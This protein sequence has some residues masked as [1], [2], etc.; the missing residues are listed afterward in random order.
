MDIVCLCPLRAAS[1]VWQ[2][3]TGAYALTVIVKATFLLKPGQSV[4]APEQNPVN[5]TERYVADDSRRSLH[6]PSDRAPYKPR[7]DVVLVG[8]AYAPGRQLVRSLVARMGVG[9]IDKSIEVWCD[10]GVRLHDGQLLKGPRFAQAAIGWEKAA[11]GPGTNNPVGISFDGAPNTFGMV[12]IPNVQPFGTSV[13]QRSDRFA[14]AGFGPIGRRWPLR[15]QKLGRYAGS[16]QEP[17]WERSALPAD[18]DASYFQAAPPDQQVAEIRPDERIFLENLHSEHPRLMTALPGL[19]PRAIA[20]RATGEREEVK[21][22]ADTLWID[23]DRGLCCVVWRGRVGLRH[24]AE[25]GRIAVWVDGLPVVAPEDALVSPPIKEEEEDGLATMTTVGPMV[26]MAEPVLPFVAGASKLAPSNQQIAENSSRWAIP[27]G[28]SGDGSGTM[29]ASLSAPMKAPLPFG[30][31]RD[32]QENLAETI[33]PLSSVESGGTPFVPVVVPLL[34]PAH[35]EEVPVLGYLEPAREEARERE[36]S[37]V[38]VV[39]PPAMIGP[40]A[41]VTQDEPVETDAAPA[42]KAEDAAAA[43]VEEEVVELSIEETAA[44]AAEIAEDKEERRK[45]L[46]AHGL[47]DSAWRRNET[48][49]D[50]AMEEEQGRGRNALRKRYDAAYVK[51]VEGFRG[52]ITVEEYARIMVGMERGNVEA[53][54]DG[55]RVQKKAMMPVVRVWAGRMGADVRVGKAAA[56]ALQELRLS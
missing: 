30:A 35:F 48:R 16:F 47:S 9:S 23:T 42:A 27:I 28:A 21:L 39:A 36:A 45:V 18:F 4:L 56:L 19:R 15:V 22:V 49:W 38:D 54:L 41:V 13:T 8:H 5:D 26:K 53:V 25:A 44:I 12:A 52:E 40:M 37:K 55:L 11:G 2:A 43:A 29:F 10:R 33:P 32:E 20:D 50:A 7:A 14:P 3:Y 34:Q 31:Q 24:A 51:R 6:F 17:G 1:F 46:E